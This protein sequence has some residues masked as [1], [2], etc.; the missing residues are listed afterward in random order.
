MLL[1][2]TIYLT[3]NA[4]VTKGEGAHGTPPPGLRG[5]PDTSPPCFPTCTCVPVSC[6]RRTR[7]VGYVI[8]TRSQLSRETACALAAIDPARQVRVKNLEETVDW[9]AHLKR[10]MVQLEEPC[11]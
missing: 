7:T 3:D 2:A 5:A 10:W 8:M 11:V 9:Q 6:G 1:R 4:K